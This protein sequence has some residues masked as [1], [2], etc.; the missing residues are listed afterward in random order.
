M[1]SLTLTLTPTLIGTGE[2][3]HDLAEA[4]TTLWHSGLVPQ[5]DPRLE[6]SM[7]E[8]VAAAQAAAEC[9]SRDTHMA[10][11]LC[12]DVVHMRL[13]SL[14]HR[15]SHIRCQAD[16]G[17]GVLEDLVDGLHWGSQTGLFEDISG[18]IK[19]ECDE[20]VEELQHEAVELRAKVAKAEVLAHPAHPLPRP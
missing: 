19:A 9:E 10:E 11:T 15:A 20:A 16:A 1:Q 17:E 7:R 6:A 8:L 12:A 2:W 13:A 14:H 3:A 5:E 4:V 18:D